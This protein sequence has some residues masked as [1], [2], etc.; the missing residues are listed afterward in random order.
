MP[1]RDKRL[2]EELRAGG[3]RKRS[4]KSASEAA[5]AGG[6]GASRVLTGL[7]QE[8]HEAADALEGRA[9]QADEA[10]DALEGRAGQPDAGPR[11]AEL[12]DGSRGLRDAARK[13][14]A[15]KV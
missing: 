12:A 10:A 9:G 13:T 4:A 7:A 11:E 1:K 5:L 3:V 6:E 8:L 15:S 14:A 2:Y